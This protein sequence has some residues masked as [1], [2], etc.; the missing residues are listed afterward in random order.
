MNPKNLLLIAITLVVTV[1]G[2][3]PQ[4]DS[5]TSSLAPSTTTTTDAISTSAPGTVTTGEGRV[6]ERVDCAETPETVVI[7]CETYDLIAAHYV[8]EVDDA[9]LA[10]A[11]TQGLEALDGA[12][13]GEKLICP[14]PSPAFTGVCDVAAGE[15]D[16]SGE[17]AQAIVNGFATHALDANSVYLDARAL[18][19]LEEEQEGE[20][21]GIGALVSPEDRTK[22]E[23]ERQCSVI[24][25][26]CRIY[27]VST[28]EGAPAD[29]V[30]L[31]RDDI[32][33]EVDGQPIIGWSID[34]VTAAV[35]GPAGSDVTLTLERQG[36]LI[37][38]TLTRAQVVIPIIEY[39]LFD[40][41][42]YIKLSV[43]TQNADEQF[44][45]A[46]IDLLSSD[47]DELVI[48]LRNNPG[49][50]LDTAVE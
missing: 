44:K 2:C 13:G 47:I 5:P 40:D 34:A 16:D 32:I 50:L 19:L 38:V 21:E 15:A 29:A 3:D 8:D 26:T 20:I 7:V 27:I 14:L 25:N 48:D 45:E 41:T 36:D 35:R 49:G 28:I 10:A 46:L 23:D 18:D 31:Q 37:D 9:T 39:E 17:A 24:S 12:D 1:A 42:G 22:Q 11:A 43:F 30:G 33:M 4:G 6:V